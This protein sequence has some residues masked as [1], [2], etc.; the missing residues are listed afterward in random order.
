[1]RT[2]LESPGTQKI[3]SHDYLHCLL[4]ENLSEGMQKLTE[5]VF[6]LV[7]RDGKETIVPIRKTSHQGKSCYVCDVMRGTFTSPQAL[8]KSYDEFT[9]NQ[10]M[11]FKTV[12]FE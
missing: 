12:S 3:V 10:L 1:M 7:L 11:T 2:K 6:W 8:A 5:G 4:F 9:G